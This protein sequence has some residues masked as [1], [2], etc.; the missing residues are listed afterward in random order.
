VVQL[1]L[2]ESLI[3][4]IIG[5]FFGVLLGLGVGYLALTVPGWPMVVPYGWIGIA[6][7]VGVLVGVL[8]GLYPAW[9]GARVDPIEA[10]RRE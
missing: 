4:G 7:V 6:V 8:A 2:V 5:A 1:F 9:R 10:L 3:L